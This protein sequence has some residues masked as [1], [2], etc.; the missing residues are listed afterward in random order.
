M[1]RIPFRTDEFCITDDPIPQEIATKIWVHHIIPMLPIRERLGFQI[2]P[3]QRSGYRPY[4]YEKAH[5]R[6][7]N[8]EHCFRGDGA[9]DWTCHAENLPKLLEELKVS[10]YMRVCYYQNNGFV[11]CDYK[12]SERLYF[13]CDGGAWVRKG[14]R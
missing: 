8:S 3:S 5:G 13:E 9:V 7:G 4:E 1:N 6:S 14:E 10:G 2:W 12:G 11:H